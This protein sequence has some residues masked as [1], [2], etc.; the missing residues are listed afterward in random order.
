MQLCREIEEDD[1]EN[2]YQRHSDEHL[3]SGEL[4]IR[5]E[6]MRGRRR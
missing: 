6:G 2:I 1:G 5:E 4:Q 3:L